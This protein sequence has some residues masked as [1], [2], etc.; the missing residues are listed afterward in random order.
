MSA[1]REHAVGQLRAEERR[2]SQQ[3]ALSAGRQI[4]GRQSGRVRPLGVRV[5]E[6][7]AAFSHL[8]RRGIVQERAQNDGVLGDRAGRTACAHRQ[9][10]VHDR[11]PGAELKLEIRPVPVPGPSDRR[12][13]K[14]RHQAQLPPDAGHSPAKGAVQRGAD[15]HVGV[16]RRQ[17][18]AGGGQHHDPADEMAGRQSISEDSADHQEPIRR[19]SRLVSAEV[20]QGAQR[21]RRA[22]RRQQE[23]SGGRRFANGAEVSGNESPDACHLMSS[24]YKGLLVLTAF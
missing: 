6:A 18:D 4:A 22:E 14:V 3:D 8:P 9:H 16:R 5:R 11:Q 1:G 2:L 10:P 24:V 7:A 20:R 23:R 21:F 17:G 12:V 13:P 19:R 15:E